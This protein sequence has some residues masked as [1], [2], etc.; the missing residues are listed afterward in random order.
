MPGEDRGEPVVEGGEPVGADGGVLDEGDRLG[1][2]DHPHQER[3]AGLADL[4][5]VVLG[6]LGQALADAEDA[7][8]PLEPAG[9]V[10]GAVGQLVGRVGVELR[11]EDGGGP[12]LGEAQ[13]PGVVGV[14]GGEVEH[15]PVDHLDRRRAG[16]DDLGQPVERRGDRG[17]REDHQPLRRRD[18]H[19][20]DLGPGDHRQGPLRPDDQPGQVER[21]GVVD[22]P[23][24]PDRQAGDEL[25]EV[26][27]ADPPEDLREVLGDRRL[28]GGR[29]SSGRSH[30]A[31]RRDRAASR[32]R[33]GPPARPGRRSA[34]VP[35]SRTTSSDRTWSTVLPYLSDR[36]PAELLPIIPPRVARSPVETSGPNIRP[37]GRRWALSRSST[38][39]GSTLTVIRSRST[40][41]IRLRCLE[42]SRIS[43]FADGLPREAGRRPPGDDRHALL[44]GDPDGGGQVVDGPGQDDADRLDLVEAGVGGVEPAVGGVEADLGGRLAAE[45]VEEPRRGGGRGGHRGC[46]LEGPSWRRAAIR[47]GTHRSASLSKVILRQG[48]PHRPRHLDVGGRG[49]GPSSSTLVITLPTFSSKIK[50]GHKHVR[51][52]NGLGSFQGGLG[53]DEIPPGKTPEGS[54]KPLVHSCHEPS[55]ASHARRSSRRCLSGIG[56]PVGAVGRCSPWNGSRTGS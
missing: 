17:E 2:A 5:E 9:Q 37:S 40:I 8:P 7:R 30:G 54:S 44:G 43:A 55:R 52:R 22:P 31:G 19:D 3:D 51:A 16:R 38:T 11:G 46:E 13:A 1:V 21:P 48:R 53:R 18:R 26:V 42:R 34:R 12:P 10:L 41:P 23:R 47:R 14:A 29:P 24:R 27:P 28:D 33:P 50:T 6:R 56:T 32:S 36:A 4:P 25:V 45:P 20:L 15:H 35:S 49:D 39:P